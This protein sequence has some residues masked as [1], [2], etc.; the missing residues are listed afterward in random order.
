MLHIACLGPAAMGKEGYDELDG[1]RVALQRDD[2]VCLPCVRRSEP[3][4]P[5]R[6]APRVRK[7]R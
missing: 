5:T 6:E 7:L 3:T 2:E 1:E 4:Q